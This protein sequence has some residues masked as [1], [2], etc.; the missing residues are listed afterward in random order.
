[1]KILLVHQTKNPVVL[2]E[3]D[4]PLCQ[5]FYVRDQMDPIV[6]EKT[7][8]GVLVVAQFT[9]TPVLSSLDAVQRIVM[10]EVEM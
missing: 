8:A 2:C 7:G 10:K 9:S 1:M 3:L 5:A 6:R 4:V